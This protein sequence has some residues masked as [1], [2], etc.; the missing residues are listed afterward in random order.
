LKSLVDTWAAI[1]ITMRGDR[2]G[3]TG[4][5]AAPALK[6]AARAVCAWR[7]DCICGPKRKLAADSKPWLKL[8]RVLIFV[9]GA[10]F[11]MHDSGPLNT[12]LNMSSYF[13]YCLGRESFL[14]VQALT[15]P[16]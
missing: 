5:G 12:H 13:R 9:T 11:L 15:Y 10:R 1:M 2:D 7:T 14:S 3:S 8:R 16:S 4:R 6:A